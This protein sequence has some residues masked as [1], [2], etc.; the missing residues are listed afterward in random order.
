[1]HRKAMNK[2][3]GNARAFLLSR[4]TARRSFVLAV[5]LCGWLPLLY[6]PQIRAATRTESVPQYDAR[7]AQAEGALRAMEQNSARPLQRELQK[8]ANASTNLQVR[9]ADGTTQPAESEQWGRMLKSLK[10]N[11]TREQVKQARETIALR[12]GALAVWAGVATE[13]KMPPVGAGNNTGDERYSGLVNSG[14][15]EAQATVRQ[16]EST[17]QI[18]TGPT[19]MEQMI[20]DAKKWAKESFLAFLKWVGSWFPQS[21]AGPPAA[22][23]WQVVSFI[24]WATVFAL[25]VVIAYLVWKAIGGRWNRT[26]ARRLVRFE[27]S[28]DTELLILPPDE[29]R[30]R[31]RNLAASGNFREALRHLYIAL[32]LTLDARGIWHYDTR[33]TN[34]EHIASLRSDPMKQPI[35]GPLSDLTRRFDRVRYGNAACD[36]ND[37]TRF[38]RDVTQLEQSTPI[39]PGASNS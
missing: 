32:L 10:G 16:L 11:A 22:I 17:G 15:A 23:N 12:R 38:E 3:A 6:A 28:E 24:F 1:M 31:A 9:R 37:W 33:R 39:A 18:R 29:L 19:R 36:N 25:L 7:L 21:S 4:R 35:V 27:G 8:L 26:G 13:P 5:V 2:T 30:D 20:S 34:W 14:P